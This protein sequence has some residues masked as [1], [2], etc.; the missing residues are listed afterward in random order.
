MPVK[1]WIFKNDSGEVATILELSQQSLRFIFMF[2]QAEKY[3]T[4]SSAWKNIIEE[5][6]RNLVRITIL[7]EKLILREQK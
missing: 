3:L 4:T 7:L 6:S 5:I 1:Y 2:V